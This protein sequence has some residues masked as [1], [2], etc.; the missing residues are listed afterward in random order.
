[1]TKTKAKQKTKKQIEQMR[2]KMRIVQMFLI[3]LTVVLV[4][5]NFILTV[6]GSWDDINHTAL[7]IAPA[8]AMA[9]L[10]ISLIDI[11][12]FKADN[13]QAIVPL[14]LVGISAIFY[15]IVSLVEAA[16]VSGMI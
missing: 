14:A 12:R 11:I 15:L 13:S 16:I 1:M 5:F 4:F 6:T 2:R 7:L 3:T 10:G 9:A 8:I